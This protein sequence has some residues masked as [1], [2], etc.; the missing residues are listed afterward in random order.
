MVAPRFFACSSLSSTRMAA[1]SAQ[2]KPS[3][4]LS[5]GRLAFVGSSLRVESA[6]MTQKLASPSSLMP[7]S[8]PP[9]SMTSARPRRTT[10]IASPIGLSRSGAGG[11]IR[12]VVALEAELERDGGRG[13]VGQHLQDVEGVDAHAAL[14]DQ[15][16]HGVLGVRE[17][18]VAVAEEDAGARE[19]FVVEAEAGVGDGLFGGRDGKLREAGHPPRFF[20]VDVVRWFEAL[21]LGVDVDWVAAA[22]ELRDGDNTGA[23]FDASLPEVLHRQAQRR[24]GAEARDNDAV[25]LACAHA[26][27]LTIA[28]DI[29]FPPDC[30]DSET[31]RFEGV[32]ST[33][34]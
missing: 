13:H 34:R 4:S 7:A 32:G 28:G 29:R 12:V 33:S 19:V 22:I 24:D 23:A 18:A 17:T 16:S 20:V 10:S 27:F 1:P 11:D 31:L 6:R 26:S 21:H 25:I 30:S 8:V 5:N 15:R 14:F 9:V 2:T 3:R